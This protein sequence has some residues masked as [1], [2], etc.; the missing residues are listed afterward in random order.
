MRCVKGHCVDNRY[1]MTDFD[2]FSS[3]IVAPSLRHRVALNVTY[4]LIDVQAAVLLCSFFAQR[5]GLVSYWM[6]LPKCNRG[7]RRGGQ[8]KGQGE[9]SGG[10]WEYAAAET[11]GGVGGGG[12]VGRKGRRTGSAWAGHLQGGDDGE[13]LRG[14]ENHV[15]ECGRS[16]S[17][18]WSGMWRRAVR[19]YWTVSEN[20][21]MG[22]LRKERGRLG[23][24][25]G[26]RCGIG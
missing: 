16:C 6:C 22:E 5:A 10:D 7:G 3:H 14:L 17:G 2:V 26:G 23:R 11:V 15:Q 13:A 12:A 1:F 25:A 18:G 9:R 20:V 8:G 4:W 21:G 19:A 24:R